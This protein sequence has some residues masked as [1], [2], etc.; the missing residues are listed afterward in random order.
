MTMVQ[1]DAQ[2]LAARMRAAASQPASDD[3][4][5]IQGELAAMLAELGMTPADGG[6]A[7]DFHGLDPLVGHRDR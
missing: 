4:F 5:D 7:I 2:A 1:H 3:R 6:G